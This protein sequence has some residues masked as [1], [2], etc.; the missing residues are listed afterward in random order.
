[1]A[2]KHI[3]G[4]QLRHGSPEEKLS[5]GEAVTIAKRGGKVFE[6]KRVDA[7]EK[8][9]LQGLDRLLEEMP[10]TGPAGPVDLSRIIIED[11]E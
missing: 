10:S 7:G 1:M 3:S 8:S 4:R 2:N 5:P 9:I 11:R 6:L